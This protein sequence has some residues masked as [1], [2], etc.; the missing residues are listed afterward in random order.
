MRRV[1]EVRSR[2]RQHV[3]ACVLSFLGVLLTAAA[4]SPSIRGNRPTRPAPAAASAFARA[5]AIAGNYAF[6]G[7]PGTGGGRGQA[8]MGG[9]MVH[10]YR[11][12]GTGWTVVD[13]LVAAD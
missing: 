13:K 6:V 1:D 11:R 7:E 5:V 10:V 2:R 3:L 12:E 8:A 9:G 4:V